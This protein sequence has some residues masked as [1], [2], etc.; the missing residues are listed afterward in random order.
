MFIYVIR[1]VKSGFMVMA[2]GMNKGSYLLAPNI[3][4]ANAAQPKEKFK[5][6]PFWSEKCQTAT[7]FRCFFGSFRVKT[8]KIWDFGGDWNFLNLY[9]ECLFTY[10]FYNFTGIKKEVGFLDHDDLWS[11]LILWLSMVCLHKFY[12]YSW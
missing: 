2:H 5:C 1:E 12:P 4:F 9:T 3:L 10:K 8:G 6:C 7:G 11:Q